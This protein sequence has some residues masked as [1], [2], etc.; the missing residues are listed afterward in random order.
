M[1]RVTVQWHAPRSSES[2]RRLLVKG[3]TFAALSLCSMMLIVAAGLAGMLHKSSAD[4]PISSMKGFAA[5]VSSALFSDMMSMELP[6]YES[7]G[8]AAEISGKQAASFL[9]RLLTDINPS[10]PKSMIAGELPGLKDDNAFLLRGGTGVDV[11]IGPE[12]NRP[13]PAEGDVESGAEQPHE[14]GHV[15]SSGN[16]EPRE[17]GESHPEEDL[18]EN[19]QPEEPARQTTGGRKVVFI[20]H[21]HS[22]ESWLPE[23]K[24]GAKDPSS[25]TK[26][27][28]LVGKRLAK[29]LERRGVGAEH[30]ATDYPTAIDGYRWELSYKYS[31][32]TVTDAMAANED[33][34]F[35]FDIHRDSQPRSLTT[36][37]INGK[38]YA[39]VYFIIGHRNPRWK[40]NEAFATK[41][42]NA[43]EK[44]YPGISRGI[45]GKS[46]ATGNGEYNQSLSTESVIIEIGGIENT[47]QE[48]Y[49]TAD[50]LAKVITDIYWEHEKVGGKKG[51]SKPVAS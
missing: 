27:I 38:S 48:S 11:A 5:A 12:D 34:S 2:I 44:A 19:A 7:S 30:S 37:T 6:A 9:V 46:A 40:E 32:K 17:S 13:L 35:F 33:L 3:R 43:L 41:I 21:S 47:L 16:S 45:W 39:Q 51:S 23:L 49:R 15:P 24:E 28:T 22:R 25:A 8:T 31:G 18:A 1:K 36:A 10:D 42:H 50:A 20:Y 4:S 29:M 26:N 14:D